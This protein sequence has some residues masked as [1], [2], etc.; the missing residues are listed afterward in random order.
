MPEEVELDVRE[1][2]EKLEEMHKEHDEAHEEK[3][4]F[5]WTR[6][7]SLSTAVLAVIAAVAALQSGTLVNEALLEQGKATQAQA[8]ASDTWAFYQAKSLKGHGAGETAAILAAN[9]VTHAAA[10]KYEA[11]A[12]RY[13]K[14]KEEQKAE[15]QKLEAERDSANKMSERFMHRHHTFAICVTLTQIAI[16]LSAIAA[17]TRREHVWFGSLAVGAAGLIAL[18]MGYLAH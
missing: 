10:P 12:A 8:R 3:H 18:I 5:A 13:E 9:P 11:M 1:Q 17:L 6:L 4:P 7:I 16:A 14:E 15:A 2:Q